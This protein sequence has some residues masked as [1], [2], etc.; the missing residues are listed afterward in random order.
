MSTPL[1]TSYEAQLLSFQIC[2]ICPNYPR[3][4]LKITIDTLGSCGLLI[5]NE[6]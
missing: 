1:N 5:K 3:N 6:K 4:E 2:S